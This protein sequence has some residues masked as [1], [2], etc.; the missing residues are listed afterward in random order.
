LVY[1]LFGS[2]VTRIR[3]KHVASPKSSVSQVSPFRLPLS[4]LR[5]H[6][7]FVYSLNL[8]SKINFLNIAVQAVINSKLAFLSLV[9]HGFACVKE[10]DN[11]CSLQC[12]SGFFACDKGNGMQ[13]NLRLVR[14]VLMFHAEGDPSRVIFTLP[15]LHA[16]SVEGGVHCPSSSSSVVLKSQF[17]QCVV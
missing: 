13:L 12:S 11:M 16:E 2:S 1:P 5:H 15:L 8:P 10:T 17:R 7:S 6:E 3:P 9:D 14:D 4:Q